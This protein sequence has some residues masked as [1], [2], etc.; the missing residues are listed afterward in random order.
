[1]CCGIG[2]GS[3]KRYRVS[4]SFEFNTP[5][6]L[7]CLTSG[8]GWHISS[9]SINDLVDSKVTIRSFPPIQ[10]LRAHRGH[11]LTRAKSS[12]NLGLAK[13]KSRSWLSRKTP[14]QEAC[15][16]V[17]SLPLNFKSNK[18]EEIGC[19]RP[20]VMSTKIPTTMTYINRMRF[21]R[22]HITMSSKSHMRAMTSNRL[23]MIV[24]TNEW[25]G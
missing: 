13:R 20:Y 10:K 16:Y 1:M 11:S 3:G 9:L 6:W 24:T 7:N 25:L 2:K 22:I 8:A 12:P 4:I 18:K 23:T 15:E 17:P 14:Q 5:Q 19:L 21:T